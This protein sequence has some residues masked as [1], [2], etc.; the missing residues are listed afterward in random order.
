M[1]INI[2]SLAKTKNKVRACVALEADF[3][4]QDIDIRYMY[5][6]RNSSKAR[7]A[8]QYS[9][10]QG[11]CSIRQILNGS[12]HEKK[13]GVAIY[14]RCNIKVLEIYRSSLYELIFMNL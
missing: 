1:F 13:C 6:I 14:L 12:R 7:Y 10:Y 3:N 5:R 8:G 2:C 4:Y 9:D 11:L